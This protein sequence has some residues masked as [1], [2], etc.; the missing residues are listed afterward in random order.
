MNTPNKESINNENK[1]SQKIKQEKRE[2]LYKTFDW[3]TSLWENFFAIEGNNNYIVY[4]AL[5]WEPFILDKEIFQKI[6]SQKLTTEDKK[7]LSE[8]W[9][10][11]DIVSSNTREE[12]INEL[13]QHI[14]NYKWPKV[15][16]LSISEACNLN[17]HMC[18]H[19]Y[20][21]QKENPRS[22]TKIMNFETAKMWIDYY[23]EYMTKNHPEENMSFHFGAAEPLLNKKVLFQCLEYI[24]SKNP[25]S[26]NID[27]SVNT[28]LTLLN[29]EIT[30]K[31]S[32]YT[33]RINIGLDGNKEQNDKIRM[34]HNG[35]G[36]H[37][38]ITKNVKII[39]EKWWCMYQ[40]NFLIS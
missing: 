11:V 13:K 37:D 18:I 14:E 20:L 7:I 4:N 39:K 6:I 31:L 23:S 36:T 26:Q 25:T 16:D 22:E 8:M 2:N 28:N 9:Y 17:C 27:L 30:E 40:K 19:S 29:E 12:Y 33:I 21:R 3:F 15:L 38:T 5:K 35:K 32:K 1:E 34:D 10:E 24:Q